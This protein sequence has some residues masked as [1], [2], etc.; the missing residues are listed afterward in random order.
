MSVK[1]CQYAH[2]GLKINQLELVSTLVLVV[3]AQ[4]RSFFPENF[5][6]RA[7]DRKN[8]TNTKERVCT[9]TQQ[10]TSNNTL[11][12]AGAL[13]RKDITSYSMHTTY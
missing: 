6:W 13:A 7:H 10:K 5:R 2:T 12:P 8:N 9:V 1:Y 4:S 3:F 11:L